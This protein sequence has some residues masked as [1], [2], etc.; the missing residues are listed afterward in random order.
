MHD[1]GPL[2]REPSDESLVGSTGCPACGRSAHTER[3][4]CAASGLRLEAPEAGVLRANATRCQQ[5]VCR[6]PRHDPRDGLLARVCARAG[7]RGLHVVCG[8]H[9][10]RH[11]LRR[12]A[13]AT[14]TCNRC[15]QLM[16]CLRTGNRPREGA[17]H[18][19]GDRV[20]GHRS[21]GVGLGCRARNRRLGARSRLQAPIVLGATTLALLGINPAA[22]LVSRQPTWPRASL[23]SYWSGRRDCRTTTRRCQE[24][25]VATGPARLTAVLVGAHSTIQPRTERVNQRD[26][27]SSAGRSRR[28]SARTDSARTRRPSR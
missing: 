23:A 27:E 15:C 18:L 14:P 17:E 5:L 22:P 21:S 8:G 26:S 9:A 19:V 6:M 12:K 16:A 13:Q 4:F 1:D 2:S 11:R 20:S 3:Q 7:P 25:P 10:P 24:R 28:A